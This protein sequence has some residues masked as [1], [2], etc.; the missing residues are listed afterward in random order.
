MRIDSHQH[1]WKYNPVRDSW[2]TDDMKVIQRDFLPDD[3]SPL[4]VANRIDG[5]VAVQANQSEEETLFLLNL[6]EHHQFIK[7]VVG[8]VDLKS[9][10][11]QMRLSNY[12][13]FPKLKGF[14]HIVQA[15]KEGFLMQKKFLTG[16]KA[17]HNFN[18]TYDILVYSRQLEEVIWFV[19][20]FSDHKFVIDHIAK[21]SIKDLEFNSWAKNI[22]MLAAFEN[23]SCKLSGMVTEANWKGWRAGDFKSYLDFAFESFGVKRLMYGSDWPVCMVAATYNQQ[24]SIVEDYISK[25]SS[26]EKELV[27][28]G[29][30]I[31]FY[32]L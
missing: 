30:A 7:G 21:P 14:R 9:D 17:L 15:E 28:G 19:N 26:S 6:A 3:L 11:I 8:W 29:N 23:V 4:L 22:S 13:R 10:D 18:Y 16:I 27:M 1:F 31:R 12:L 20:K 32:N 2:I 24:L 5:C 25:L